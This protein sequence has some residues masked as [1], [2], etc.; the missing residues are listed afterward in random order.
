MGAHGQ[1]IP[2]A[3]TRHRIACRALYRALLK[4]C[5][6]IPL[7]VN[8]ITQT[9]TTT[10]STVNPIKNFIR[11]RFHRNLKVLS[12]HLIR[13]GLKI[14]YLAEHLLR[15]AAQGVPTAIGQV[16]TVLN[17]I[18]S[19]A[20]TARRAYT[21]PECKSHQRLRVWPFPGA[22]KITETRPLPLE[23]ISSG[24]RHVPSLVLTSGGFPFLRFKK[25]Q[26]PYL[27]RVIRDRVIQKQKMLDQT[28]FLQ[29]TEKIA[30]TEDTWEN[31]V[32]SEI[33]RSVKGG[34][35]EGGEEKWWTEGWGKGLGDNEQSW[36]VSIL[37]AK[38]KVN[39]AV[40]ADRARAKLYGEKLLKIR[41]EEKRLCQ[42]E[43]EERKIRKRQDRLERRQKKRSGVEKMDPAF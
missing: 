8:T 40:E 18:A 9:T 32:L 30:R 21:Q 3:S 26:S 5:G 37:E 36:T 16:H 34:V 2:K 13:K 27:S 10:R 38:N 28:D 19:E 23:K 6:N 17:T 29:E 22:Q 39:L 35:E 11:K 20:E 33:D 15:T 43:G 14:G 24:R 1:F 25:H 7:P 41:E 4:P 42:I 12:P 31:M